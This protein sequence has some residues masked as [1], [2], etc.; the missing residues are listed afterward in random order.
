ML[1]AMNTSIS[2]CR[3]PFSLISTW[4]VHINA[5]HMSFAQSGGPALF[6]APINEH[7]AA[8]LDGV[9][10]PIT[11]FANPATTL[12]LNLLFWHR[13]LAHHNLTD[14]KVLIE[15]NLVTGM[16][17]DVKTA[18]DPICEPCHAGKMHANPFPS[19]S[20]ALLALWGWSTL[21]MFTKFPIACSLGSAIG[22]H[23]SMT[24]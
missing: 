8:F 14:V 20:G 1:W 2:P 24:T 11:E 6:I 19:S 17:L 21:M 3:L 7:N 18:P 12:P 5:T 13:R 4:T 15:C 22:S 23:S 16:Q 9:A 10:E